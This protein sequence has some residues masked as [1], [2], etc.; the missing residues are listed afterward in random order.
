M[1]R[2]GKH[3][4]AAIAAGA[5]GGVLIAAIN[6]TADNFV[7]VAD[8]ATLRRTNIK[9]QIAQTTQQ[10]QNATTDAEVQK[11]HGVL[12]SLNAEVNQAIGSALVET[13]KIA[14]ISKNR[15]RP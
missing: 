7:A 10:L 6:R 9:N 12:T 4:P 8:N 3:S 11:L 5:A 13:S 14:T 1:L 15:F 2:V